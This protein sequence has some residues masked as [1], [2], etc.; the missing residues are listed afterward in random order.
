[1]NLNSLG[2]LFNEFMNSICRY[3]DLASQNYSLHI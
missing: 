1:M 2:L 3:I